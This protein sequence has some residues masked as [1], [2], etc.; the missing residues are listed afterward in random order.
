MKLT[1]VG[2]HGLGV[3]VPLPNGGSL[4]VD[5]GESAEF[6]DAHAQRLLEQAD[7]WQAAGSA[8]KVAVAASASQTA[9]TTAP[10]ATATP[11]DVDAAAA[12]DGER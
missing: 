10:V 12:E 8:S 3:D 7:N 11:P 4:H 6:T 9:Q 5:P 1:Y 2:P